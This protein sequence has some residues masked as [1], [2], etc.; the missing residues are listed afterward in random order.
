MCAF[1]TYIP[2]HTHTRTRTHTHCS[3]VKPPDDRWA[4][5]NNDVYKAVIKEKEAERERER[6]RERETLI[7]IRN[8]CG[9][10]IHS[11]VLKSQV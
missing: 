4:E 11:A 10:E 9:E 8:N 7:K 2:S 6:E 5:V 3:L 1:F